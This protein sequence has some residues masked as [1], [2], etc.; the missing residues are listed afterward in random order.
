MLF[1][2]GS[3]KSSFKISMKFDFYFHHLWN[4]LK[5][6]DSHQKKFKLCFTHTQNLKV[7]V[8]KSTPL[9]KVFEICQETVFMT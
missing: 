6:L 1:N 5:A 4:M 2:I 8:S 7:Q 3:S 9:V